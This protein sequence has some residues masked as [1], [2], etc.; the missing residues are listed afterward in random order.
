MKVCLLSGEFPP[1]QG[2]V[3][4]FTQEIGLALNGLGATVSVISS[5]KAA[6]QGTAEVSPHEGTLL[7]RDGLCMTVFP[8]IRRWDFSCWAPL[9]EF[10]ESN[11]PEILNVQYQTAAYQMHPAINLLPWV[12]RLSKDR[13]K[14]VVTFHDLK[15]PYLFPKAGP[16]RRWVTTALVRGSDAAI[17][18]NV[19][20][21]L[22]AK[23]YG[24]RNLYLFPI[25]SNIAPRT[26][27][28]YD[29]DVWR[30]QWG[31]GPDE[32][33]VCYFGFL[34]ESKGGETLF[35]ALAHLV[36]SGEPVKLLMIGGKV[37]SSDPTN[38]AYLQEMESLIEELHLSDHVLWTGYVDGP[39]VSAS[40]WA[41]D[42]CAMPYRDGVSFRR[43]TLM[44]ALAHGMPIISTYPQVEVPEIVEGQNMALVPAGDADALASKIVEVAASAPLRRRLAGGAVE[45]SKSFTWEAIAKSTLE[46]YERLLGNGQMVC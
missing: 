8:T 28:G 4:D 46:L 43:G 26:L 3:G 12:L 18:T 24:P 37:G 30:E 19:E 33:L 40:F 5:V 1:M 15:V 27:A 45:L 2:G 23:R 17:V 32:V 20:D 34:N 16:L 9:R 7:E 41:A 29:R 6:P 31:I 21:R 25:G 38:V 14:M 35:R 11:R 10:L 42:I 44:A 39:E 13:P 36:A 22:G